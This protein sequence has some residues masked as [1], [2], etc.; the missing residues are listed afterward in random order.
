M[1]HSNV[2]AHSA[3]AA[4]DWEPLANTKRNEAWQ[5]FTVC[6]LN[7]LRS[8]TERTKKNLPVHAIEV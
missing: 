1:D 6:I 3:S 2:L 5:E 8:E 7:L 4:T